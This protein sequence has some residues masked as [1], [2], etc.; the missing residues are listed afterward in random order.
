MRQS[1]IVS[2]LILLLWHQVTP[3]RAG[4]SA[5][6]EFAAPPLSVQN[7]IAC[8]GPAGNSRAPA[9]PSIAGLPRGYLLEVLK[10]YRHGGRFGTIMGRLLEGFSDVQLN[11]MADYFSRQT[12]AIPK[13]RV[14][15]DLVSRGRQLHRL[16]CR[17]CH[18]D[19]RREPE[20]DTPSLN[21]GWMDYLR[22]TLQDYLLG[23]NQSNDEM[24]QALIH[25]IRRHSDTGLEALVHYYGSARPEPPGER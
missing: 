10:A 18:G 14:D 4:D 21:G 24:S 16:Y 7:C 23:V 9:I 22:W 19:R 6:T 17:E 1:S 5:E 13:Q 2:L 20:A 12:A 11:A 3:L 25:V 8:H 15:W